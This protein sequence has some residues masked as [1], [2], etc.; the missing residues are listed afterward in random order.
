VRFWDSSALVPLLVKESLSEHLLAVYEQAGSAIVWWGTQV[1]CASALVRRERAG[2]LSP[3]AAHA[4]RRGLGVH[5][6]EWVEV[7]PT[8]RVRD[9]A[10]QF[11][12][13]HPLRAAD[14]LQLAAAYVA[15]NEVPSSLDFVC[16]DRRLAEAAA[17]EGFN[18]IA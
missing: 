8:G 4:A 17:R 7:A 2:S 6:K 5:S 10:L 18:V 1:E 16:L 9:R 15:A 3:D 14:A 11:L 13:A 12:R